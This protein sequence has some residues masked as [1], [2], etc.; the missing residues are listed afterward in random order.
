M[1]P[2]RGM[3][4][5]DIRATMARCSDGYNGEP[6]EMMRKMRKTVVVITLI[7]LLAVPV[8]VAS[9][10]SLQY[11]GESPAT[12]TKPG[13]ALISNAGKTSGQ[14]GGSVES[15]KAAHAATKTS[16]G[17]L[18]FTGRS[19]M[20]VTAVGIVLILGG[21]SLGFVGRRRSS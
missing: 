18:P 13:P 15:A 19:L 20:V 11:N 1:H 17:T 9:P 21:L 3:N 12:H 2:V 16:A 10:G 5:Q 7:A 6:S 4:R 14:A 8:A